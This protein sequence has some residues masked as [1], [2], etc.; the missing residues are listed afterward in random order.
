MDMTYPPQQTVTRLLAS[1]ETGDAR[2]L[3][4]LFPLVYE[5]LRSLAR[6]QRQR[7]QG[8]YTLNSTALVHEAYLKLV[9]QDGASFKSRGHFMAVASKAMRHIL[10]NYAEQQRAQKRGGDVP[11]VSFEEMREVLGGSIAMTE[12][13]AEDFVL[14]DLALKKLEQQSERQSRIVECRFFG[15]LTIADTAAALGLSPA[16]VKRGW[17]MAQAWLHREMGALRGQ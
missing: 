12:E 1:V 6:K 3:D 2:A 7:W 10:I 15:G 8:D 11:K 17:T 4:A 14:L 5:E 9:D 13:R 16:T